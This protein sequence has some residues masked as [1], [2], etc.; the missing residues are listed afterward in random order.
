MAWLGV[1]RLVT[2]LPPDP[3][4]PAQQQAEYR[5]EFATTKFWDS[6]VATERNFPAINA[7]ARGVSRLGNIPLMIVVG[8]A[9][10]SRGVGFEMQNELRAL[11]TNSVQRVVNGATHTSL[12]HNPQ[13][14]QQTSAAILEIVE[15][16]R[17]GG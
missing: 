2:F 6:I 5:A 16:V 11:S 12:L 14:A 17:R 3:E 15:A 13:H 8:G 4:L 7:Q 9:S 1:M 10:E